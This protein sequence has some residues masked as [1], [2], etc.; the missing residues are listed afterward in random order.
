MSLLPGFIFADPIKGDNKKD[1]TFIILKSGDSVRVKKL[2]A[3]FAIQPMIKFDIEL[4]DFD[5]TQYDLSQINKIID[6]KGKTSISRNTLFMINLFNN[7]LNISISLVLFYL[8][9][10]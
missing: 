7:C 9:F 6:S 3:S 1:S 4:F 2:D 5:S 10:V 8:L